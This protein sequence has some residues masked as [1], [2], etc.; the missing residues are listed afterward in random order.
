MLSFLYRNIGSTCA[1]CQDHDCE[2]YVW[3][4]KEEALAFYNRNIPIVELNEGIFFIHSFEEVNGIISIEKPRPPCRL[5][6]A[7]LCSIYDSKPLVC[8]MYPIGLAVIDDE[9][10]I[11]LHKDCKFSRDIKDKDRTM[12]IAQI[13]KILRQTPD[14]LLNEIMDVYKKVDAISVLPN[15]PNAFEAIM[16]FGS[17]T[18]ERR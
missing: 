9:V 1:S 5:R 18:N 8:R 17:L 16:P 6:Q 7:R 4:L 12:F 2:G 10:I 13:I 11:V 15:G 14:D 3:L